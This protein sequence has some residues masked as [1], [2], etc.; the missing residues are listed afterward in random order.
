M[1]KP[2][3]AAP[4]TVAAS[5]TIDFDGAGYGSLTVDVVNKGTVEAD[6][7]T[8]VIGTPFISGV[9]TKVTDERDRVAVGIADW[10]Q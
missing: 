3:V 10:R 6:Q 7:G 8:L 1:S 9:N 2:S 4:V 5:A